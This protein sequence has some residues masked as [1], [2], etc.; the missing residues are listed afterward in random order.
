M[1]LVDG[2]GRKGLAHLASNG[3]VA[4]IPA[5][6]ILAFCDANSAEGIAELR[7]LIERIKDGDH[8]LSQQLFRRTDDDWLPHDRH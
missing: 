3:F 1:I 6:D 2:L 8:K 7:Q 4:A 5:R